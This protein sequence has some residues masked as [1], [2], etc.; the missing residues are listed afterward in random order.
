MNLAY[1]R[2]SM[3]HLKRGKKVAQVNAFPTH[4]PFLPQAL[5]CELQSLLLLD[6]SSTATIKETNI[7]HYPVR[8]MGKNNRQLRFLY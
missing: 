8:M 1:H 2:A 6:K 3:L 7:K 5:P 4:H